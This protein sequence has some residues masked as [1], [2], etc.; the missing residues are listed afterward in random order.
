MLVRLNDDLLVDD[1]CAHFRRSD[2]IAERAGGSMV[3]VRRPTAPTSE[4]E[5][6]EIEWHLRVWNAANPTGRAEI[7]N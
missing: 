7:V 6:R 2:F 4:Q 1:L 3:D 5:R